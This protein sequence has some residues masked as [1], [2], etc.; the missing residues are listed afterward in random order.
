MD[1][2]QKGEAMKRIN[3][4]TAALWVGLLIAVYH[5]A[6][7][8]LV[9]TGAAKPLLDYVL[10]LHSFEFSYTITPFSP[11]NAALLIVI[12][13][14]VGALLGLVFSLVWNCLAESHPVRDKFWRRRGGLA[15]KV[16]N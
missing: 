3:P 1:A 4:V 13:Y 16:D 15:G 7:V 5:A 11:D 10:R 6:W 2:R 12:S 9:A 14:A 8:V